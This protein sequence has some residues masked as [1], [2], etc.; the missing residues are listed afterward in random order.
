MEINQKPNI[1]LIALLWL[2]AVSSVNSQTTAR[3]TVVTPTTARPTQATQRPTTGT[4][5]Q[6]KIISR[7]HSETFDL[8]LFI[9]IIFLVNISIAFLL[10]KRW[11]Y[12]LWYWFGYFDYTDPEIFKINITIHFLHQSQCHFV[13]SFHIH[14]SFSIRNS[15]KTCSLLSLRRNPWKYLTLCVQW[16][17]QSHIFHFIA[18]S[19]S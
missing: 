1:L 18:N 13:C 5:L 11:L 12:W 6:I 17:H 16:C 7:S 10:S 8:S 14:V 2:L 9:S 15:F 3:P 4:F 19:H